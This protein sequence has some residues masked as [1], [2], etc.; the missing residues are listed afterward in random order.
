MSD[1]LNLK[2]KSKRVNVT[3]SNPLENG[4]FK[5]EK[6]ENYFKRELE[7]QYEKGFNEAERL[8]TEKLE[9]E[10]SQRLRENYE[11]ILEVKRA[12]DKIIPEFES[13]FEKI[14]INLSMLIAEK[15]VK[16]EIAK[17]TIIDE[18]LK[19]SLKKV[20]GANKVIVKLNPGDFE[21]LGALKSENFSMESFD[22][23][24]FEQDARIEPGGCFIETE[25]G[26]ADAKISSQFNEIKKQLEANV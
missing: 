17:E 8:V 16:R 21:S 7:R 5:T 20:I 6:D 4:N 24:N 26:S 25:I 3:L 22:K 11:Q 23:I 15:I 19:D 10:F 13:Y 14:V 12:L 2:A 18:T 1:V 9:D